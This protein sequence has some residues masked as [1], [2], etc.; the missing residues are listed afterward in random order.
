MAATE[1]YLK[2]VQGEQE[3]ETP[4]F[5]DDQ[6]NMR[7][8]PE[9]AV[10]TTVDAVL[11]NRAGVDDPAPNRT[12]MGELKILAMEVAAQLDLIHRRQTAQPGQEL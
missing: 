11:S 4:I 7:P 8:I 1:F 12:P 6:G 10:T 9:A 2:G 3:I 5:L